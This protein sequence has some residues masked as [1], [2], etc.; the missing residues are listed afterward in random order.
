MFFT[1]SENL[2][3]C[4]LRTPHSVRL[5]LLLT[6]TSNSRLQPPLPLCVCVYMRGCVCVCL[7]NDGSCSF[8]LGGTN[9]LKNGV[10]GL[11]IK[12]HPLFM[13]FRIYLETNDPLVL[14]KCHVQ[15]VHRTKT[16]VIA[17]CKIHFTLVR[18]RHVEARFLLYY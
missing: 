12:L 5:S 13:F 15:L 11:K 3:S 14:L 18:K 16:H 4:E 6:P 10:N 2:I 17:V 8:F 1:H 9:L 7:S